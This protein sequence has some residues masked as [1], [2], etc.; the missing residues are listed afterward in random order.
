MKRPVGL[1]AS[2]Q[3]SV[4]TMTSKSFS[5]M[6]NLCSANRTRDRRVALNSE[7]EMVSAAQSRHTGTSR[8]QSQERFKKKSQNLG[9]RTGTVL[10]K[11][12]GAVPITSGALRGFEVACWR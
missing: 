12:L 10:T 9:W 4:K 11:H 7:A 3:V 1:T 5:D 8:A 6:A 2:R